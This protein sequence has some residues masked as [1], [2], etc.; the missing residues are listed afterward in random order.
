MHQNNTGME[1]TDFSEA[2][3]KEIVY[4]SAKPEDYEGVLGKCFSTYMGYSSTKISF[5][6][7]NKIV[8]AWLHKGHKT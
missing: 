8:C 6:I 2:D 5:A 7:P 1:I 4:R 3:L